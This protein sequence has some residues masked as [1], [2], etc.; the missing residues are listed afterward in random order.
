MSLS[1]NG[2][3]GSI[4][5]TPDGP[6]KDHSGISSGVPYHDQSALD[7]DNGTSTPS[8]QP[9]INSSALSYPGDDQLSKNDYSGDQYDD[10]SVPNDSRFMN[11]QLQ[12]N[13]SGKTYSNDHMLLDVSFSDDPSCHLPDVPFDDYNTPRSP[14]M[15]N[16]SHLHS[17]RLGAND[18]PAWMSQGVKS[19]LQH[20]HLKELQET[21]S[22]LKEVM[23]LSRMSASINPQTN[24]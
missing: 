10:S 2:L 18:H 6:V 3:I 17:S 12:A 19:K 15:A 1:L 23:E 14:L 5:H 20:H 13:C 9:F 4:P 21:V 22:R 8:N 11:G 24:R 7:C 16:H